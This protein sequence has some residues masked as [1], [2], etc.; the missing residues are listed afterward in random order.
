MIVVSNSS[1]LIAL[2]SINRLDILA[3]LFTTIHIPDSVYQETVLENPILEQQQRITQAT[4]RF[5]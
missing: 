5:I 4:Q 3:H 1:P 2:S